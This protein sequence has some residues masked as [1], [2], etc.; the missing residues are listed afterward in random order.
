MI[1]FSAFCPVLDGQLAKEARRAA[2]STYCWWRGL[3]ESL[4]NCCVDA[5]IGS[6]LGVKE[7]SR[8]CKFLFSG[9]VGRA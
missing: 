9:C 7:D 6:T 1:M 4:R 5:V 2:S 8:C 3:D